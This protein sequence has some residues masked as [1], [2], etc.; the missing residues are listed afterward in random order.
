MADILWA[1]VFM[2]VSGVIAPIFAGALGDRFGRVLPITVATFLSAAGSVAFGYAQNGSTYLA[3]GI[4]MTVAL[5][6]VIPY[7]Y[8]LSA[9]I[10]PKG[11]VSAAVPGFV[12]VGSAI[13]PAA[14]GFALGATGGDY[15]VVAILAGATTILSYLFLL[16]VIAATRRVRVKAA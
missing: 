5:Y 4:V 15:T 11:R 6:F 10:D 16:P 13:G 12:A 3:A 1:L 7:I 9:E 2:S 8:A 14:G